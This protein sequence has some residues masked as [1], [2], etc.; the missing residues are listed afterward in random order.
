MFVGWGRQLGTSGDSAADGRV[1]D[2]DVLRCPLTPCS[3]EEER[4][5]LVLIRS[6]LDMRQ[7]SDAVVENLRSGLKL[8]S[9]DVS[10]RS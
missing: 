3:C 7:A 10:A 6:R 4:G 1:G 9:G 5:L 8:G 2:G